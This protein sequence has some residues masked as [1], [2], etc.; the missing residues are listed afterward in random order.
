M[1]VAFEH[2]LRLMTEPKT[3]QHKVSGLSD[4]VGCAAVTQA[5]PGAIRH[6]QSTAC[7][8]Q[9]GARGRIDGGKKQIVF[10][11][12]SPNRLLVLHQGL[13]IAGS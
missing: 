2:C 7:V 10:L 5:V 3:R 12:D 8:V 6:S 1:G 11:I 9:H 13:V 4:Q